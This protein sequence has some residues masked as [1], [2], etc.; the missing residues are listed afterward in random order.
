M[1][2]ASIPGR[3]KTRLVPPLTFAQA[4][5]INTAFLEDVVVNMRHAAE[6]ADLAPYFAFGPQ[7]SEAFFENN[8]PPELGL[9]ESWFPNFGDCLFHAAS[10]LLD[11]GYDSV[12]LLN[13]DSPTLPTALL[14]RAV[15]TLRE[16][17]DR[18]VIGPSSD[19][20]YYLLGLKSHHRRLFDDVAWS[21]ETVTQETLERAA[22]IGVE[23]VMLPEWYDVDDSVSLAMLANETMHPSHPD[24]KLKPHHAVHS[25]AALSELFRGEAMTPL[26]RGVARAG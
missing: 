12:C 14:V 21:T 8:F 10:S 24:L 18:I 1:A 20:G 23:V 26:P 11:A 6:T 13:S 5:A 4:A 7:G 17:G 9:V 19:G 22:E 15:E 3:T 25:A 2:K 16:A